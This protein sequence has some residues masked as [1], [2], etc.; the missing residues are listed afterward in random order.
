MMNFIIFS[1]NL[2]VIRTG[3]C[4]PDMFVI[5]AQLDELIVEGML[6]YPGQLTVPARL[7]NGSV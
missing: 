4:P 3:A 5:Q 6:D 2:N 1:S 7:L